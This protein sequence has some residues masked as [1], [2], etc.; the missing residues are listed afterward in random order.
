[1]ATPDLERLSAP[2]R[3]LLAERLR[4][5][6]GAGGTV[7]PARLP[8]GVQRDPRRRE[9]WR[10]TFE[11]AD[12]EPV[13]VVHPVPTLELPRRRQRAAARRARR[14][15]GE[16]LLRIVLPELVTLDEA[17]VREDRASL[18]APMMY[19]DYAIADRRVSAGIREARD[20]LGRP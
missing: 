5:A 12:G 8:D 17:A 18:P 4:E 10:S 16:R 15:D 14:G 13:Q 9:I 1:M 20:A 6:A 7:S 2:E 11:L 3:A 19:A